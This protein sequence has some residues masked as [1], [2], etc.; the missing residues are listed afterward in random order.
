LKLAI[1]IFGGSACRSS[2]VLWEKDGF[3]FG[4]EIALEVCVRVFGA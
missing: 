3:R 2:T 4:T 1:P